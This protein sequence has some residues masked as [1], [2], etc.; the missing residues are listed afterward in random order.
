MRLIKNY[1]AQGEIAAFRIVKFI[2]DA[3]VDDG[4]VTQAAD[5]SAYLVGVTELSPGAGERVDVVRSGISLVEFGG[6]VTRGQPVTA[7]AEGRAVAAA[8]TAGVNTYI[9]GYAE[10]SAVAG[11]IVSILIAPG[12]MQG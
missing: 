1:C 3:N 7:D 9:I 11:D 2:T 4:L 6:T 10:V 12:V 5:G 8:P